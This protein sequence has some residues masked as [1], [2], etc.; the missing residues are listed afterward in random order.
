MNRVA[1]IFPTFLACLCFTAYAQE[2]PSKPVKMIIPWPPGGVV[3]VVGRIVAKELS[4]SLGQPVVVENKAGA[5][6]MIGVEIA[7]KAEADGHTILVT[8]NSLAYY[9]GLYRKLSFDPVKDLSPIAPLARAPHL[10]VAAQSAP[11]KSVAE[12]VA[13]A[14]ASPGN[15]TYASAGPGSPSHL[16]G[17]LFKKMSGGDILHVPYKGAEGALVDVLGGRVQMFFST[18]AAT[19]PHM[20]SDRL[21]IVAIGSAERAA[22][23]PHARTIS[24]SGVPGFE[25]MLWIGAFAP[26][27]TPGR[28]IERLNVEMAKALKTKAASDAYAMNGL[29]PAA[30]SPKDFGDLFRKDIVK[31]SEIIRASNLRVD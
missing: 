6:G 24:E 19:L 3:D 22:L 27:A 8:S 18:I 25:S 31:W 29:D 4:T 26:A 1:T 17:E 30:G 20:K 10:L 28:I 5:G 23:L 12:I 21:R 14:K 11:F 16:A 9:P 15:L 13:Q 7:S 2:Y